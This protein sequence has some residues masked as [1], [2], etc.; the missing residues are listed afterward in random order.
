MTPELKDKWLNALR[1]TDYQQGTGTLRSNNNKFCCLGVLCDVVGYEWH[2]PTEDHNFKCVVG[3]DYFENT[4]YLD[5]IDLPKQVHDDC[6]SMNDGTFKEN[7][8]TRL[9]IENRR[10]TF[11]EIADWLERNL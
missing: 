7:D 10:Y 9:N 1:G 6:Y 11:G 3:E 4:D 8:L 2:Q 5:E